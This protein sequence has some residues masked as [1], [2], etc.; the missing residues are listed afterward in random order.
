[1]VNGASDKLRVWRRLQC[2]AQWQAAKR[3]DI[4][5]MTWHRWEAGQVTPRRAEISALCAAISGLSP[6]DFY[7]LPAPALPCNVLGSAGDVALAGRDTQTSATAISA[8]SQARG[9]HPSAAPDAGGP[10]AGVGSSPPAHAGRTR[11]TH[12]DGERAAA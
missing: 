9:F 7:D 1:M 4:S 8:S 5:R 12:H 2:L 3:F 6:N 11:A 10:C